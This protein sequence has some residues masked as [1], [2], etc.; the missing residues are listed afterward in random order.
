MIASRV[1]KLLDDNKRSYSGKGDAAN[2]L[3][4]LR[5]KDEVFRNCMDKV[6]QLGNYTA[7]FLMTNQ[8]MSCISFLLVLRISC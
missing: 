8:M 2:R 4:G 1:F 5:K 6:Q 7:I 3:R